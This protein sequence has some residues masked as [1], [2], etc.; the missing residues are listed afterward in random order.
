ML[1]DQLASTLNW[2]L[3]YNRLTFCGHAAISIVGVQ[4]VGRVEQDEVYYLHAHSLLIVFAP[5][6]FDTL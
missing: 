4:I 1:C 5:F 6:I 2:Y 3:L